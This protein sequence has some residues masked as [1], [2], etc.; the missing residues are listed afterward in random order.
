MTRK[1]G[2]GDLFL[3]CD[4]GSSVG[5]LVQD[6][7][8]VCAAVMI[9]AS[10]VNTDT[11]HLISVYEYLGQMSKN[12]VKVFVTNNIS[13]F[14]TQYYAAKMQ[15]TK[16]S[17]SLRPTRHIT[18]QRTSKPTTRTYTVKPFN[19]AALKVGDLACKIILVPYILVN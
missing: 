8:S 16:I 13:K 4:W 14:G 12:K 10:L 18:G 1:V 17:L 7:K 9:C 19:L 11:R 3:L 2:Q 6:Y 5:L 15:C